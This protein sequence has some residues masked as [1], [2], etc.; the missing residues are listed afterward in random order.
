MQSYYFYNLQIE[1]CPNWAEKIQISEVSLFRKTPEYL[2]MVSQISKRLGF[3]DN[4]T[5]SK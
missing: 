3:L 4:I 5:D 2:N 1:S